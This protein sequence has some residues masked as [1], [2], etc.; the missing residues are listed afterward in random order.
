MNVKEAERTQRYHHIDLMKFWG[1]WFVLMYHATT[2]DF[3][4]ME[5]PNPLCGVRYFLRTVLS[6]CVPLFFFANG[7]LLLNKPFELKK[8]IGK[9][10]RMTVLT[11]IWGI[12]GLLAIMPIENRY[13]SIGDFIANL[14]RFEPLG[15]INSL[16]FM[17]TLVMIY[18]MFP[19]IKHVYDT[20]R[21]LFDYFTAMAAGF[22]F[23]YTFVQHAATIAA[24][25]TGM[26]SI[27]TFV[28]IVNQF[29]PFRGIYGYA[30]VYFCIGGMMRE[31]EEALL[32]LKHRK[33]L[34]AL[35]LGL[36][37]TLLYALGMFFSKRNGSVWDVVWNGYNTVFTLVG[38]MCI[39]SLCLNYRGNLSAVRRISNNTLGIYFIHMILLRLT[40]GYIEWI[41]YACTCTGN[42]VYALL[43]VAL[44]SV[45]TQG[46]RRIPVLRGLVKL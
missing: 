2:Y 17:G 11:V 13:F 3:N 28:S 10:V 9:T 43:V 33:K 35:G 27:A 30:F 18:A 44:C 14:V 24:D 25:L 1:I 29:N 23:V 20:K 19:L 34:A 45:I 42:A 16:W 36:S 4:W 7:Y 6:T 12:I 38:V 5:N 26:E 21:S 37:C 46:I 41:P 39:Y 22:T 31:R 15:W 32:R 40:E 8:H